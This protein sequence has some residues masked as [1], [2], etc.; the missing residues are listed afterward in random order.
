MA[1]TNIIPLACLFA[2]LVFETIWDLRDR[3]IPI[4]F[5]LVMLVSGVVLLAVGVSVWPVILMVVSIA[6]TE[7]Y[8]RAK[9]IALIGIFAPPGLMI[10]L[11]PTLQPLA[12][13]WFVMVSLWL[14]GVIGGADA[15]A[16]LSLALFF[17]STWIMPIAILCGI[18]CWNTAFLLLKYRRDAGLRIWTVLSAKSKG[19]NIAGIGAYA[20]AVLFYG[21]YCLWV[22]GM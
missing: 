10:A 18:F 19:E 14:T 15:L 4:W 5:S 22:A 7:A 17:P 11:F 12:I 9:L 13:C 1:L 16:G 8:R 21:V 3:N 6:C 2:W 20:L